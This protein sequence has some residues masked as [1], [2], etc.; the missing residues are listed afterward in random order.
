[1][2]YPYYTIMI[3]SIQTDKTAQILSCLGQKNQNLHFSNDSYN[4][5]PLTSKGSAMNWMSVSPQNSYVEILTL[6]VTVLGGEAFGRW[7]ELDEMARWGALMNGV[8]ALT[9]GSPE[10]SLILSTC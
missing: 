6:S 7:L 9:N 3:S 1:M 8:N 5:L 10:S 4:S 2:C